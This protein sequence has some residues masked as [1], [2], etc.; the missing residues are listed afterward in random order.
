MPFIEEQASTCH[1]NMND[2]GDGGSFNIW[3]LQLIIRSFV[4]CQ[5]P[6]KALISISPCSNKMQP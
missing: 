1:V 6:N 4:P 3:I 5:C 2:G